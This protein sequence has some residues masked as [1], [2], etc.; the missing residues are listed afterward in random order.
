MS[1]PAKAPARYPVL[2]VGGVWVG[3][4]LIAFARYVPTRQKLAKAKADLEQANATITSKTEQ[5]TTL[6]MENETL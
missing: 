2:G 3:E 5:I 1:P 4:L 6:Q